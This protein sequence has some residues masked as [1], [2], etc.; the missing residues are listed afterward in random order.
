MVYETL[1][2]PKIARNL[3]PNLFEIGPSSPILGSIFGSESGCI[4]K[5]V[6]VLRPKVGKNDAPIPDHERW[7]GNDHEALAEANRGVPAHTQ[8]IDP[9][10]VGRNVGDTAYLNA[11][12][13]IDRRANEMFMSRPSSC[14][15][16]P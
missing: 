2:Q 16:N 3:S 1:H 4:R 10:A 5:K 8:R 12:R 13:C 6:D 9:A 15:G 14:S 11:V 7:L